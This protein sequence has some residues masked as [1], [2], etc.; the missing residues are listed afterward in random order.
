MERRTGDALVNAAN[1]YVSALDSQQTVAGLR[2]AEK[3]VQT[4]AD[5]YAFVFGEDRHR[6]EIDGVLE[7]IHAATQLA[8]GNRT[9]DYHDQALKLVDRVALLGKAI[10]AA[11]P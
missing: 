4:A 7:S 2:T 1:Q 5:D 6:A 9:P 8:A 3:A 10:H 11:P